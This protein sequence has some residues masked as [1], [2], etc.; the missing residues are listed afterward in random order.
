M[1][2]FPI[3]STDQL[4]VY[5]FV[6]LGGILLGLFFYGGLW[7]T[8]RRVLTARQPGLLTIGSFF[9]RTVLTLAGFFWLTGGRL[10]RLGVSMVG[11]LAIRLLL[12]RRWGPSENREN[13]E[14]ADRP[15]ECHYADYT[16]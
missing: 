12:I 13:R 16:G 4:W 14:T 3:P 11:F 15:R 7:W 10:D 9:V 6:L 1:N 8:V 5:T 2:S